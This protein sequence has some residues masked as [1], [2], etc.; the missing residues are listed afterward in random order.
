PFSNGLVERRMREVKQ[1]FKL[2]GVRRSKKWIEQ[3]PTVMRRLNNV[4]LPEPLNT[5]PFELMFARSFIS[6]PGQ[7]PVVDAS[8]PSN[9]VCQKQQDDAMITREWVSKMRELRERE[10]SRLRQASVVPGMKVMVHMAKQWSGPFVVKAVL[11]DRASV[12]ICDKFAV[13][14]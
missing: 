12:I 7:E 11:S 6:Q 8:G 1:V 9:E 10:P 4:V 14:R 2:Y 5:T 13:E 3:L